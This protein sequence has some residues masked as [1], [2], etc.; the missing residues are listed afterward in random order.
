MTLTEPPKLRATNAV[1][2]VVHLARA[3]AVL[4]LANDFVVPVTA[5]FLDGPPGTSPIGSARPPTWS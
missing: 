2:G 5:S 4:W 3:I 1:V